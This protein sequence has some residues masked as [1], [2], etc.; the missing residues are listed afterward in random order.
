MATELPGPHSVYLSQSLRFKAPIFVGQEIDV[1]MEVTQF[2]AE[3]GIV[4]IK[5]TITKEDPEKGT[6]LCVE[7]TA[8][9]M[10][11]CVT[12]EGESPEWKNEA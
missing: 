1:R 11:K 10:N 12:F 4:G 2:R 8:V 5:T 3:K 6:V 7:G 9:A